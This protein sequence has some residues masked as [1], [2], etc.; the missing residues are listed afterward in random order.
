MNLKDYT[1]YDVHG[2]LY[3]WSKTDN[4]L[5]L[6]VNTASKCGFSYQLDRFEWLHNKYKDQGL[7]ILAFPSRQFLYQ[8]FATNQ[9]VAH[10]C[11]SKQ[12]SF[13]VMQ[14]TNILGR[15]INPLFEKLINEH[16]W[17][18]RAKAIKWNY[19]K[20]FVKNN[21]VIA[22]F[23]SDVCACALEEFIIKNL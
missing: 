19:E 14:I 3:D 4:K 11:R 7:V 8:E 12:F 23:K 2:N 16:P 5:V 9:E 15:D 20:F 17:S 6:I 1:V 13:D 18:H 21:E 22:R 10:F